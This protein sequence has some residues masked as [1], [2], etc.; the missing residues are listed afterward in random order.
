MSDKQAAIEAEFQLWWNNSKYRSAFY[1]GPRNKQIALDGWN[2][3]L[4]SKPVDVEAL[5]KEAVEYFFPTTGEKE[6]LGKSIHE[7]IDH[8]VNTGVIK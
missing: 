1:S 8:L 7:F 3:A 6:D 5:K 2:A 4:Q